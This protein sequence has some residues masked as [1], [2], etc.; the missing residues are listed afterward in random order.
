M[1]QVYLIGILIINI[2]ILSSCNKED[3]SMMPTN[4]DELEGSWFRSYSN[5]VSG[6]PNQ[7]SFERGE[8]HITITF[9]ENGEF[10][11]NTTFLG[12]YEGTSDDD[13]TA[14]II[15]S[16][17]YTVQNENIEILLDKRIW[18]DSFYEDMEDFEESNYNPNKYKDMT[19]EIIN[20]ELKLEY[21]MITDVI[22]ELQETPGV[23]KFEEF[24]IR[25]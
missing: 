2:L 6:G 25:K 9:R 24:Y 3:S 11:H 7:S 19:F 5:R 21:L 20:E 16:G 12:L 18:W 17:T 10:I 4:V 22:S 14:V 13:T 1:K 8:L 23:D 15:E